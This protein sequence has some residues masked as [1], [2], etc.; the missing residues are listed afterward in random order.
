[1]DFFDIRPAAE[2]DRELAANLDAATTACILLSTTSVASEWVGYEM[3]HAMTRAGSG[4]R[5]V[6]LLLRPCRIPEQLAGM[7]AI[8]ASNGL[9]DEA[10][11]LRVM[12]AVSGSQRV[13]DGVL[14]TAGQRS[15]W[16]KREVEADVARRAPQL[17]GLAD[18]V[19]EVPVREIMIEVDHHTF[20]RQPG[21]VVELQ[22]RLNPLWTAP[23]R[24]FFARY[25]EGST[26]PGATG[27]T[28]PRMRSS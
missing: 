1:M 24:W 27:S 25:I 20:P 19:R 13:D 16:A 4:L 22:L 14:L 11:R 15:A 28:S 21:L 6:P 2:L 23:M 18:R 26:W 17:A 10:V 12:R 3:R 9:D 5:I 8:D 7:V